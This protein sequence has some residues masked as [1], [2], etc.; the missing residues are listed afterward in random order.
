M[1]SDEGMQGQAWQRHPARSLTN[2]SE[3][4]SLATSAAPE[5]SGMKGEEWG[6]QRGEVKWTPSSGQR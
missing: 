6:V 5:E 2:R 4:I 1:T 3:R